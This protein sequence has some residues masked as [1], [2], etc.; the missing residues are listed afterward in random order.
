MCTLT[1]GPLAQRLASHPRV[2]LAG[3]LATANIGIEQLV[4]VLLENR[5]I[6][7]LVLCGQ[8]SRIFRPGQSLLALARSGCDAEGFII[9]AEGHLPR[10]ANLRP[11][12][13]A[14][15]RR[16]ITLVDLI[17]TTDDGQIRRVLDTQPSPG[18]RPADPAIA[19]ELAAG[20]PRTIRLTAGGRRT[21]I[22]RAGIGYFV[23]LVDRGA[24]RLVLRHYGT[25]FTVCHE[26]SSHSAEALLLGVIRNG[27]LSEG[28]LAH[29]G[30]LGAELAKAE[31]ALRLGLRYE[32]DRPLSRI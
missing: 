15:F 9:G 7:R 31:T 23:I 13:I 3:A 20:G 32:Q 11:A 25:D 29:A 8:D 18:P 2:G 10:L 5:R 19:A 16:R 27:L 26:M 22:A 4:T 17:G 14:E 24:R 21:P 28:D 30:Y 6:H 12:V 1:D